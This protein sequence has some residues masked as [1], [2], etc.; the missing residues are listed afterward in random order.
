VR[1]WQQ[2]HP[3]YWRNTARY[4]RRALQ[5]SLPRSPLIPLDSGI[6][7][8]PPLQEALSAPEPL[9]IGLIATLVGSPLQDDIARTSRRLVQL[10]QDILS[11]GTNSGDQTSA[12]P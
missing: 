3:G 1:R 2:E 7:N 8:T 12:A 10:G 6:E 4:K 11:G 5:D 9:L